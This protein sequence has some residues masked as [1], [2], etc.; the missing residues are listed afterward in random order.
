MSP[1]KYK[2]SS[3]SGNLMS[4]SFLIPWLCSL[5]CLSYGNV[6]CGISYLC[7][8]DYLSYGN[9]ICGIIVVCLIACTTI[10]TADGS[11]LPLIIFYALKYVLSCSFYTPQLE[12]PPSLTLFFLLRTLL[13]EFDVA[14][15]LF[16]SVVC[17]SSLVL[18]TLAGGFCGLSF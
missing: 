6:I 8:L 14:F 10:S 12:A 13:G 16:F 1:S 3:P 18:L 5:N 4:C 17:I 11:I 15:F 9:V 7:S 2:C